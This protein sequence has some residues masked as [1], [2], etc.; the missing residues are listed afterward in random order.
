MYEGIELSHAQSTLICRGL[1]ALAAV[2]GV[3]PAEEALVD[4]FFK[5]TG[6]TDDDLQTLKATPFDISEVASD[7]Q[8][9]V[10][11][12]FIM[13]CYMLIYADG[14]LSNEEQ[15]KVEEYAAALDM[16]NES[17]TALHDSARMYLLHNIAEGLKNRDVLDE[18]GNE[19]GLSAA[20]VSTEKGN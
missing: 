7:L 9:D 17:L 12:A 19:L 2:D 6:G 8:G 16:S 3:H 10:A 20:Q 11:E 18:V 1:Y 4:G 13:S 14:R 5:S 15:A